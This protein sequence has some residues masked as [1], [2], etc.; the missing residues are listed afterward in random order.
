M[1]AARDTQ[2][3]GRAGSRLRG[4]TSPAR[5]QSGT[6]EATA[7]LECDNAGG[8]ACTRTQALTV[9]VNVTLWPYTDGFVD[10][11]TTVVVLA[12]VTVWPP[13]NVPLLVV[14]LLSPP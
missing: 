8:S 2:T 1:W 9:A 6:Y 14:K 5:Q 11:A 3:A 13:V 7:L 10:E 12:G 4:V